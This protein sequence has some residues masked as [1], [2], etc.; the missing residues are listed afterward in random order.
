M[1]EIRDLIA[2]L[3][4]AC[5]PES[6]LGKLCSEAADALASP[7]RHTAVDWEDADAPVVK[8]F[9]EYDVEGFVEEYEYDDGDGGYYTPGEDEKVVIS[10]VIHG[11]I[12]DIHIKLK[13]LLPAH[14]H[15]PSVEM[16]R[17][18]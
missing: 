10:D 3:R 14:P 9:V 5:S 4:T 7:A 17:E 18:A 6:P 2:R 15:S 8:L 12:F 11:L 1:S 16:E 13:A